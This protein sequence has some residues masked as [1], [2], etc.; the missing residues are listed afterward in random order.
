MT[1]DPALQIRPVELLSGS[2]LEFKNAWGSGQ[3]TRV[4][5][6]VKFTKFLEHI[7]ATAFGMHLEREENVC[8]SVVITPNDE[9][10]ALKAIGIGG[11]TNVQVMAPSIDL[12]LIIDEFL[13]QA[14]QGK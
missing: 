8:R 14:V 1:G 13:R 6:G 9:V 2:D 7:G 5:V 12:L 4:N 3:E 10:V 11:N